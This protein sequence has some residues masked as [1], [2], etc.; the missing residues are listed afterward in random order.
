MSVISWP[1][2]IM[3]KLERT[4]KSLSPS[5]KLEIIRRKD[6]REGN[7]KTGRD[8]GLSEPTVRT[9]YKNK[10]A[11]KAYGASAKVPMQQGKGGDTAAWSVHQGSS[12]A[13]L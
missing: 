4:R 6:K 10:E 8:T 1:F 7:S 3:A 13:I 11:I 12:K 9:V 5:T 2:A